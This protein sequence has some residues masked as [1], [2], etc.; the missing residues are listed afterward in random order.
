MSLLQAEG[1]SQ[2]IYA[3]YLEKQQMVKLWEIVGGVHG[4]VDIRLQGMETTHPRPNCPLSLLF[5]AGMPNE[6]H[7]CLV[8]AGL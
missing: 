3:G 5:S 2:V 4:L 8:S 7:F 6:H 1:M